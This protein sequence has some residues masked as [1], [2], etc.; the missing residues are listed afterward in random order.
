MERRD[1]AT[2]WWSR[3]NLENSTRNMSMQNTVRKGRN[4]TFIQKIMTRVWSLIWARTGK[5]LLRSLGEYIR[6]HPKIIS[7]GFQKKKCIFLGKYLE[8][9]K[10]RPDRNR[11]MRF[12]MA[13]IELLQSKSIDS[14]EK[15]IEKK[16][17]IECNGETAGGYLFGL[18]LREEIAFWD[19]RLYLISTFEQCK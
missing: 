18:H 2:R 17:C 1:D 13:G 5:A 11:R 6:A 9:I 16:K 10:N 3:R 15:I 4:S 14:Y 12:F 19:T 8:C 7:F